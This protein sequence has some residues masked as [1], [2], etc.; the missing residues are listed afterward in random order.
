MF[1]GRMGLVSS[2]I[3]A[4]LI[5]FFSV[6]F[7]I[8]VPKLV[9]FENH[10]YQEDYFNSYVWKLFLFDY[11]NNYSAFFFLTMTKAECSEDTSEHECSGKTLLVLR[12]QVS[13]TLGVLV[14][15]SI[16]EVIYGI[17]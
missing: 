6:I 1:Q 13:R 11:V 12:Q 10:K 5:K 14:L 2:A 4:M 7:E 3:L 16:V 15:C 8:I 17:C 9:D